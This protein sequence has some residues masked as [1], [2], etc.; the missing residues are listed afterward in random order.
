M[1]SLPENLLC[2]QIDR[3][4]HQKEQQFTIFSRNYNDV[5]L[6]FSN[7]SNT[8]QAVSGWQSIGRPA[9]KGGDR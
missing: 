8:G 9:P 1:A 6:S 3:C 4:T 7:M 2:Q 5:L